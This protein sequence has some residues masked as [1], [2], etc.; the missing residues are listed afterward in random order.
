M[1]CLADTE[2]IIINISKNIAEINIDLSTARIIPIKG[3]DHKGKE[4]IWHLKI[5]NKGRLV[6][7]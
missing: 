5:T 2:K 7:L 3:K 1:H 4:I 6:L